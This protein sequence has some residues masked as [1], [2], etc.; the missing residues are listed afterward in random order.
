MRNFIYMSA[1]KLDPADYT[2]G[3]AARAFC[4]HCMQALIMQVHNHFMY[5]I[6]ELSYELLETSYTHAGVHSSCAC[7]I[8]ILTILVSITGFDNDEL[9]IYYDMVCICYCIINIQF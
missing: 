1:T 6:N 3:L 9:N 8:H 4:Q 5:V 7:L 2:H